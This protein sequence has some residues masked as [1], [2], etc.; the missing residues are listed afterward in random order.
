M[1]GWQVSL[2][3]TKRHKYI[4]DLAT[5]HWKFFSK[6]HFLTDRQIFYLERNRWLLEGVVREIQFNSGIDVK[7]L[8][9]Q[10]N[11]IARLPY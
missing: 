9:I 5:T 1:Q 10:G 2:S 7:L 8:D 11:L 4:T 6:L 3:E